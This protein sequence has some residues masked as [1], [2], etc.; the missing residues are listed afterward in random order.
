MRKLSTG[1]TALLL[2]CVLGAG[3]TTGPARPHQDAAEFIH[4]EAFPNSGDYVIESPEDIYALDAQV[5]AYL[6]SR[7]RSVADVDKR[8]KVL[9]DEIFEQAALNL[10]YDRGANTTASNTFHGRAANC[11]SLSILAYAMARYT[12]FETGFHEVNIPEYWERRSNYSVLNRHV[13]VRFRP[14]TENAAFTIIKPE[15]EV[16]FQRL[17]GAQRPP[18]RPIPQPRVTA[19]FY[20]NKA[21]DA[22]FAGKHDLAYAYLK[23][24]L[25]QDSTLAMALTNIGLLYARHGYMA[26]AEESLRHALT[27]D[28]G[29]TASTEN[30]AALLQM[31]G[32]QEE[33][34]KLIAAI[35]ARR[36][37][38]PYY[39]HMQ[40][41]QAYDAGDWREA[42]RL[43]RMAIALKTDVD[44]FH[45]DLAKAYFMAGDF[46]KAKRYMRRAE[47]H[48]GN[49]ELKE[50]YRDKLNALSSM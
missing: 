25:M 46:E 6:D 4:D 32:R 24:A 20:N 48:A 29:S 5:R 28:A 42:I 50:K 30:L 44:R 18:T 37:S 21:V 39:V 1:I 10:D 49:D 47:H 11:L 43:F 22:L 41:E 13:N 16:D 36:E 33:A 17:I 9:L 34:G 8:G 40:G 23:A 14:A 35:K 15:F 38:N 45:F 26:W 27:L 7:I 3:C 2:A 12:G 19:M 31:T